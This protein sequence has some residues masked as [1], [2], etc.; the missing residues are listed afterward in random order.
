MQ[1]ET[2]SNPPGKFLFTKMPNT[3]LDHAM[4]LLKD[5]EWRLL[6]VI[7]RQT[8]GWLGPDGKSKSSDWLTR[9]QLMERTGRH[10]EAISEAIAGLIEKRLIRACDEA[11]NSLSQPSQRRNARGRIQYGLHPALWKLQ[12]SGVDARK[13]RLEGRKSEFGPQLHRP[14]KANTTIEQTKEKS[15]PSGFVSAPDPEDVRRFK[16]VY[17]EQFHLKFGTEPTGLALN[18]DDAARLHEL[19]EAHSI[20]ELEA[21]LRDFFS[22]DWAWLKKARFSLPTFLHSHQLLRL[23]KPSQPALNAD[24]RAG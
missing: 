7:V 14:A 3:L 10:S 20:T 23:V 1:R 16:T 8:I 21:M 17:V 12:S 13:N 5:T 24:Q 6:C 18:P 22:R 19:V 9:R 4:P 11:G 15:A 2:S